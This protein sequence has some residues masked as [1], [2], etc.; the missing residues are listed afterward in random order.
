MSEAVSE[1]AVPVK[2]PLGEQIEHLGYRMGPPGLILQYNTPHDIKVLHERVRA[3]LKPLAVLTKTPAM[4]SQLDEIKESAEADG[5]EVIECITRWDVPLV[6][7]YIKGAKIGDYWDE[8]NVSLTYVAADL[9]PPT[10]FFDD[11]VSD[12]VDAVIEET[13]SLEMRGLLY[14]YP[15]ASTIAG[16]WSHICSVCRARLC[17]GCGD[18]SSDEDE[19]YSDDTGDE[20]E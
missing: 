18:G 11:L 7:I 9:H 14:G 15:V 6:G 2:I 10:G 17:A 3:D 4:Q 13:A 5:I 20:A 16:L 8:E 19:D 1:F 12:H